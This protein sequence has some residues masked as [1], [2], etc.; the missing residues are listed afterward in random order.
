M[1]LLFWTAFSAGLTG[2]QSIYSMLLGHTIMSWVEAGLS[3]YLVILYN[4]LKEISR[5]Q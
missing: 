3:V 2:L 5:E 4:S 1:D